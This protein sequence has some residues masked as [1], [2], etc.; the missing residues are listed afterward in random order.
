MKSYI[1]AQLLTA[2]GLTHIL[3]GVHVLIDVV[4]GV[5]YASGAG[6]ITCTVNGLLE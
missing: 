4:V 6:I 5:E 1:L 3:V 2:Y